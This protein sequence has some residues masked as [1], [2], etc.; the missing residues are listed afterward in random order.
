MLLFRQTNVRCFSFLFSGS[1]KRVVWES[2]CIFQIPLSTQITRD[3]MKG[4]NLMVGVD[5]RSVFEVAE[6]SFWEEIIPYQLFRW[7]ISESI[8]ISI[9]E[10][11]SF[12]IASLVVRNGYKRT[13]HFYFWRFIIFLNFHR[14]FIYKKSELKNS[15]LRETFTWDLKISKLF[16]NWKNKWILDFGK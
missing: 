2:L 3:F 15:N 1:L 16:L 12:P 9:V 5:G 13:K 4:G 7:K 14:I 8:D 10:S 6:K 11:S